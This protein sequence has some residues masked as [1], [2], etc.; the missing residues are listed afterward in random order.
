MHETKEVQPLVVD[1]VTE[2]DNKKIK[3]NPVKTLFFTV[4][5]I[6]TKKF[7]RFHLRKVFSNFFFHIF[8]D[9]KKYKNKIK[10]RIIKLKKK[11][12]T[13]SLSQTQKRKKCKLFPPE[14]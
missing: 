3:K 12:S 14:K 1:E 5:H 9:E 7:T 8:R 6:K 11:K 2:P 10:V 13:R 4:S